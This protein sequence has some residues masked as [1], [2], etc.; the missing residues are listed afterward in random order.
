MKFNNDKILKLKKRTGIT[1]LLKGF[2]LSIS[3]FNLYLSAKY[4]GVSIERDIWLLA[5]NVFL[6]LD[7]TL[8]GPINETFRAKFIFLREEQGE[9]V[10]LAKTRSL[11]LLTN[12]I[13]MLI[14]AMVLW[15]PE[16]ISS[17]IAPSY[18]G[19]QLLM[20]FFM[21]RI[22]APSFLF[23]QVVQLLTSILNAYH[24]IYIPEVVGLI[25]GLINLI[26]LILLAPH[27]GILSLVYAYYVGLLLL[28]AVLIIQI[29]LKN[30][31]LFTKLTAVKFA[32]SNT[33]ILFA[34]PFFLPYFIGQAATVVEKSISSSLGIGV[35]ST[36]DYARK[37]SDITINILMSVL[38]TVFVPLLSS[39]FI[40]KNKLAF[41]S[42]LR[43]I[44][45]LGFLLITFIVTILTV[46]PFAVIS[47]I[48]SSG[49]ISPSSLQQISKLTMLYSWSM[50][51]AFLYYVSGVGL[52]SSKKEKYFATYGSL[53]QI[54]L[55]IINLSLYQKLGVYV[56]P[57]ALLVSH[58]LAAF[59]MFLKLPY[60]KKGLLKATVKY[61]IILLV[62]V[63][64]MYFFNAYFFNTINN[65]LLLFINVML[66]TIV[67]LLMLFAF[68]LDERLVLVKGF[69]MI[70]GRKSI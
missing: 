5:I 51:G 12:G 53:A 23:N 52:M 67:L 27:V 11:L 64:I 65:F 1:L 46:C 19:E 6:L 21:I 41:V 10:A 28:L 47:L 32:D 62:V 7:M 48:Y 35:V 40:K 43:Q 17:I 29:R 8:W 26:L 2:R 59:F 38:I 69:N 57:I 16:L 39:H 45:Q 25:S 61:V 14:V 15:K 56:F 34:L 3:L 24:S 36:I 37:F 54:I 9:A 68:K 4:F 42:D 50:F 30:I 58:L 70:L 66:L 44:Y 60:G 55:I 49:N 20:L 31:K 33:F 22:M 13:T 18:K 63:F